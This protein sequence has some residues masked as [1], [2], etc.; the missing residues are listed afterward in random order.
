MDSQTLTLIAAVLAATMS[1]LHLLLNSRVTFDRERRLI[2]WRK[3]VDRL[4]EVEEAAGNLVEDAGGYHAIDTISERI[5]PKFLLFEAMAG[6]LARYPA[7]RQGVRDLHQLAS[8]LYLQRM[9][10][11]DDREIRKELE[12][13]LRKLLDACDEVRKKRKF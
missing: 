13:A 6:K 11:E 12:P 5:K 8:I 2:L 7:V 3:E 9:N 1:L 10:H 4:M